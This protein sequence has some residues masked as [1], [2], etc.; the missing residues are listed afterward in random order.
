[1]VGAGVGEDEGS[2]AGPFGDIAGDGES[3]VEG[4]CVDAADIDRAGG[5]GEIHGAAA[6]E[7][8]GGQEGATT[9]VDGPAG[10]AEVA[11]G[12]DADNGSCVHRR[13]AK[14][15]VGV[16]QLDGTA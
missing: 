12:G 5:V 7:G 10:V 14:V 9:D 6:G 16:G 8:A 3:A 1:G 2:G 13:A 11:V 4:E 15:G